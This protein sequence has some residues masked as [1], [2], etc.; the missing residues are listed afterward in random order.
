M[1]QDDLPPQ[2]FPAPAA[3]RLPMQLTKPAAT[4]G[5]IGVNAFVFVVFMLAQWDLGLGA[6][7]PVAAIAA[8]QWWRLLTFGFLHAGILHIGFNL[9]ALYGLGMLTERFF[10][11]GRFLGIYFTALFGS[12]VMVTLFSPPGLPTV[13]ASGAIMGLLGALL[14][15]Y[16]KYRANLSRGRAYLSE[17]VKM[18]VINIGIGFLPGISFWGHFGGFLA[19][20]LM[21]WLLCPAYEYVDN[22]PMMARRPLE[23]VDILKALAAPLGLLA[24]LIL[25]AMLRKG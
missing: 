10:G 24:V 13:G 22:P 1:I 2:P 15:F 18:A 20:A 11:R 12:G 7:T 4:Y 25:G 8:H 5:L 3:Q 17:L 19:G 21:G 23:P 14:F 9:Y 16:W 6:L